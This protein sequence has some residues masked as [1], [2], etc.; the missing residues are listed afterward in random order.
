MRI[1]HNISAMIT[2]G[3]LFRVDRDLSKSLEKLST[4]LRINRAS[5]DAAGLGVSENLR[6]QVRGTAQAVRN[7][8]DGIAAVNIAE[9]AANEISEVLQRMR[10]L[11]IQ[12]ANDTLTSVERGYTN[13]EYR[14]LIT[15]IDRIAEVTNY[16]GMKLISSTGTSSGDRFGYGGANGDGSALWIDANGSVGIDSVT[17]TIDTL[18]SDQLG[19]GGVDINSTYLTAQS[20]SS[21]AIS[22]LDTAIDSVNTMRSNM[23][24][25]I[26]RM[27]HAINNLMVSN[28]NQQAAE[29]TIRDVDFA[30]ETTKFTRN[31]ILTQSATAMLS[32]A[33]MVQQSTLQL[34][35]A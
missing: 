7:A 28:T 31:Q 32:Q 33:N 34:L 27:E 30:Q 9:G 2:Q 11:A 21:Q 6:T 29:S 24:A 14:Q 35:G 13:V 8:Q 15:E 18:T 17:V 10:E 19:A 5:D 3:S 12:S 23:G 4:G 25:F 20:S 26:N 22:V 16:N 1:N